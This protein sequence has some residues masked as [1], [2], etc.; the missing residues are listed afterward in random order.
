MPSR[1]RSDR[2][3]ICSIHNFP[4]PGQYP[5]VGAQGGNSSR[6]VEERLDRGA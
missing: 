2:E 6:A 4:Y 3:S 1:R 5:M